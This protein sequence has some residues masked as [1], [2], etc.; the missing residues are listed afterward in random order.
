MQPPSQR[1]PQY[2][3]P[4]NTYYP[5]QQWQQPPMIPPPRPAK[6][7]IHPLLILGIVVF[8]ILTVAVGY[9]TRASSPT[10]SPEQFKASA[11]DTTVE[12]LDKD[13]NTDKGAG[14][15]FTCKILKFVK[16]DSGNTAGANVE[17]ADDTTSF[18]VIQ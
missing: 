3:P 1:Q 16:D 6:K 15:H 13:A 8:S 5:P 18:T 4:P 14:V 10:L 7:R 9:A 11:Q 17:D 12:N 2:P